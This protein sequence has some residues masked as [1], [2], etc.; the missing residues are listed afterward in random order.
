VVALRWEQID[1][2][3]AVLHVKRIKQGKPATHPLYES[4]LRAL[5]QRK[6][7]YPDTVYIFNSERGAPLSTQTVRHIVTTA[8]QDADLIFPIHPHMLRHSTGY[9][10]ANNG[11]DTRTIQG[12]MGHANIK[13]TVIYT[14]LSATRFNDFWHD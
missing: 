12:Y 1:L 7:D 13:N 6:R 3:N 5:R 14:E 4:E 8:G 11:K 9:Y 10:L 2:K